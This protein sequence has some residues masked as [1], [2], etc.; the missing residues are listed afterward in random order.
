MPLL[1]HLDAHP[2]N[3][4][5]LVVPDADSKGMNTLPL[6]QRVELRKHHCQLQE[7]EAVRVHWGLLLAHA[8]QAGRSCMPLQFP[9]AAK[10]GSRP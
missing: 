5:Q 3:G 9:G 10:Q 7:G 2:L 8:G 4:V 6:A 1:P